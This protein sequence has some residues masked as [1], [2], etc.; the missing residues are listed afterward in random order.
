MENWKNVKGYEELYEVSDLGRVRRK[1][2]Y[3][4][5]AIKH[6]E[7]VFRKGG[8]LKQNEKR[9]G[10]LTVDLSKEHKVRTISIHKLVA[11]AFCENDNPELKTEI[12]HINYNKKDNRAINLEWVSPREN[13][14]RAL[15]NHLY[16]N[17]NKKKVYCKQLDMTFSSSYEAGEYLNQTFFKNTKAV[18]NIAGKIRACCNGLQSI[19]YGF[20]WQYV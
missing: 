2:S 7:Y 6:N 3:V 8:I 11:V 19:A 5:T 10:Y 1:D 9:N 17:P 12:D 18:K 20:N 4:K 15:K 13:K 16:Y 14:D